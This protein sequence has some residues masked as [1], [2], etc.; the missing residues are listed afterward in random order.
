MFRK[1]DDGFS[2]EKTE[3]ACFE[4]FEA[5][6]GKRAR[7]ETSETP[8]RGGGEGSVS[9]C[10]RGV[11][12]SVSSRAWRA[13]SRGVLPPARSR[14]RAGRRAVDFL[15]F[16]RKDAMVRIRARSRR[17]VRS[18]PTERGPRRDGASRTARSGSRRDGASELG[19][20]WEERRR[21]SPDA[22][23]TLKRSLE[24]ATERCMM[25]SSPRCDRPSRSPSRG[26]EPSR[27][28]GTLSRGRECGSRALCLGV[29]GRR[30][31]CAR[32]RISNQKGLG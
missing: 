18:R 29:G 30:V 21:T 4:A 17:R 28:L 23:A 19:A 12:V 22:C 26:T 13:R 5:V 14:A 24:P 16:S 15:R 9:G 25:S 8:P 11:M 31:V 27:N 2:H 1:R 7:D 10:P 3:G 20:K 6:V 32:R